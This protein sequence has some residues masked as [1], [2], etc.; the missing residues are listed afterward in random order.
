[1]KGV[2]V[3]T[4]L[5]LGGVIAGM[6]GPIHLPSWCWWLSLPVALGGG[7]AL[8]WWFKRTDE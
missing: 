5:Y 8:G 7:A 3:I 2:A 1:M 6:S 4:M